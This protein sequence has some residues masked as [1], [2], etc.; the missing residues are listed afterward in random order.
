MALNNI[1]RNRIISLM[2]LLH[3]NETVCAK[4]KQR[5]VLMICMQVF[6]LFFWPL[7]NY[8]FLNSQNW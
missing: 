4:S 2:V 3:P 5:N 1:F 7:I 8:V 6:K